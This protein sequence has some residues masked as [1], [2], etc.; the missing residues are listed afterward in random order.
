M[1]KHLRKPSRIYD[2]IRKIIEIARDNI[3]RA[4][5]SEMVVAY[6]YIG[7]EIVE[8]EQ[9]GKAR[10]AYGKKLLEMLSQ[11]LSD[12]FGKGFDVSN[13]WNMRQFYQT[14]PIL[15]AVRRE[16]SWTHYRILMRI[17][18]PEA[19]SFYEVECTSNNWSSRELE[20]QKG[21]FLFERLALSKD[22]KGIM[23]L[24]HKGQELQKYKTM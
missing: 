4:V 20:R 1:K 21:S 5:N 11:R 3:A 12:E 15:D 14:Y 19:R 10:A 2:R 17:E 24:A 18:R 16:L 23:K 9:K 8:E 6:W 13:L 22:K 7:K